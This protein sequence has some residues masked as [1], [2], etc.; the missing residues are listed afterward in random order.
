VGTTRAASPPTIPKGPYLH[1]SPELVV[2]ESAAYTWEAK[3]K[4]WTK[5]ATFAHKHTAGAAAYLDGH[6]FV[7]GGL[8]A[9]NAVS[10]L[11][12]L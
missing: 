5:R 2:T 3:T 1:A 8:D 9:A 10:E 4:A 6:V 7:I 11:C 12:A